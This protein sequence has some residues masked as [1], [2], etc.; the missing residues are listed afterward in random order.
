MEKDNIFDLMDAYIISLKNK[1]NQFNKTYNLLKKA[2][3]KNVQKFEAINGNEL[4]MTLDPVG[5]KHPVV[6]VSLVAQYS[7]NNVRYSHRE[8]PSKGVIGC[9]LSHITLWKKLLE[10]DKEYMLIFEDDAVPQENN[11]DIKIKELINEKSDFD[12]ILLGNEIRD[13]IP[14]K[15]KS[16]NLR[17]CIFFFGL[18]AY[19]ISKKAVKK[20]I[21]YIFPIDIQIDSY[22]SLYN[23]KDSEFNVYHTINKY[24]VQSLHKSSLQDICVSCYMLD[25]KD[26]C[27]SKKYIIFALVFILIIYVFIYKNH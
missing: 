26:N 15:N 12:I 19:I 27:I 6:N 25:I 5:Y 18:H 22:I 21:K 2:G 4:V 8:I 17:K 7:I 24:V 20:L 11:L 23:K 16:K 9:Y 3:L 10:S 1:Q 14:L 13:T